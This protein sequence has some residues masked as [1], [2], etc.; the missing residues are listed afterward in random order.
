MWSSL[1]SLLC[2]LLF[3]LGVF[4]IESDET[5]LEISSLPVPVVKDTAGKI[6]KARVVFS[7]K[8]SFDKDKDAWKDPEILNSD[9]K[10]L[11]QLAKD[12]YW[13]MTKNKQWKD[14]PKFRPTV[15]TVMPVGNEIYISSSMKGPQFLYYGKDKSNPYVFQD[16]KPFPCHLYMCL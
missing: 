2:V 15:M 11:S 1:T 7:T 12:A 3:A 6:Q 8:L 10:R 14:K 16:N 4:S 9:P 5:S 13:Q